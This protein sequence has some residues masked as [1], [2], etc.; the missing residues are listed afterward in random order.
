MNLNP[1]FP[2]YLPGVKNT[3]NDNISIIGANLREDV[4]TIAYYISGNS[5]IELKFKNNYPTKEYAS[6]SD[7][8]SKFIQ[9]SQ[10]E[11]VQRL[12]I[13]VPG[14]VLDGKSHPARLK[15]W[16]LDVEEYRSKFGF[17][18]V[19]MLNDQ[20]ASAYGIGLLDDSDL[21]AIYTSGHLEK[22]NVAIL[23]PGNGLGE[24]GY[25]FDGKYL[26]PFATEGGHSEFSPR[27]NV[28]VE[29]YQF[30]NNIYG[31]VSW[32]NV[33]S[34]TGLFNIYRFLRDVKRHP[35]PEWLSERLA[36]GNFTEEIYK[37]AM[38]EDALICRIALDTFLEF[39]AREANNLTLKLKATGGLLIAGDIPQIIREYIDKDKFYEKFKISDKM[40]D[41]LKNIPIY[42]V[43]TES[44]S[45]NGAA[46]YTAYFTE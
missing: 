9:D 24:A 32:E 1:K 18:K 39:L 43:N 34:K 25:F 40:E 20:E 41:M 7:V 35:E 4:T 37:A 8:L 11:N 29:F 42:V 2:L 10:L 5:G 22:G 30:L 26:R 17:E 15:N 6:F 23:A 44:T 13:S 31:I 46:L 16:S 45:I 38:H 3:N 14:P 12:G 33:L 36:N 27:T 19:D 28:E 21:D